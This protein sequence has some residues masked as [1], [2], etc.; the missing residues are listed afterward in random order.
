M[1]SKRL[2]VRSTDHG[3]TLLAFL[4]AQLRVSNRKAKALLD[5]R[6]VFVNGQRLWMARHRLARGDDV[7]IQEEPV[8]RPQRWRVATAGWADRAA[9][10]TLLYE[11]RDYLIADKPPGILANGPRSLEESLRRLTACPALRAVHRL[12]RDTSGCLLFA[13]QAEA[14]ARIRP[15]FAQQRVRKVYHAI[16]SGCVAEPEQ[17]ITYPIERK[18][19][20]TQVRTLDVNKRASH[21]RIE[22]DTGRTHQIRRHLTAIGHP[23]LGDQQYA[24][25]RELSPTERTLRRQML[26]AYE[27]SFHHPVS[28]Q[29]IRARAP[30][31]ADFTACLRQFGLT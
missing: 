14:V 26:H 6:K 1:M 31:P 11:S 21:L 22:P 20:R 12:D 9:R 17:E 25:N 23:L 24:T 19:A 7:E 30:L 10:P 28:G 5:A 16:V 4:A 2:T 8:A 29:L 27:L 13:R 18:K 15:L 3:A